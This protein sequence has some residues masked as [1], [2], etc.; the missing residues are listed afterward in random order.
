MADAIAQD[1]TNL[2]LSNT[3]DTFP[4]PSSLLSYVRSQTSPIANLRIRLAPKKS[5]HDSDSMAEVGREFDAELQ[6][7]LQQLLRL[8]GSEGTLE[9]LTLVV[10]GVLG[11]MQWTPL[12]RFL[13]RVSVQM[14]RNGTSEKKVIRIEGVVDSGGY[15]KEVLL[16]SVYGVECE[17]V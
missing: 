6:L 12:R 7:Y 14:A 16:E 4:T 10:D 2:T 1:I 15:Q 5:L 13:N 9:K 8:T 11:D 3:G 17:L